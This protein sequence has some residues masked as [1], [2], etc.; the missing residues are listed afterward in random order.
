MR[1][2]PLLAL[3]AVA[4]L[5]GPAA[6]ADAFRCGTRLASEGDTVGQVLSKCGQPTEVQ[7]KTILRPA[8]IWRDGH[9]YRVGNGEVEVTVE[10]WTYNLGSS[11]L[12]RRLRFEDG[13]LVEVETLGR[14]YN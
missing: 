5:S 11:K 14:G 12:M 3:F 10:I 2:T 9:P 1:R 7:H 4:I 6:R 8:I 13:E